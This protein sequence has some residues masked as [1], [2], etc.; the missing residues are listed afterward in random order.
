MGA[1]LKDGMVAETSGLPPSFFHDPLLGDIW[2]CILAVQDADGS[3]DLPR[4]ASELERY[5]LE[6]SL[7]IDASGLVDIVGDRARSSSEVHRCVGVVRQ[8]YGDRIMALELSERLRELKEGRHAE[9]LIAGHR[10]SLTKLEQAGGRPYRTAAQ[11]ISDELA[12]IRRERENPQLKISG[13]E[14]PWGLQTAVPG[15]VP[16]SKL[17]ILFGPTGTFK[18]TIINAL[19]RHWAEQDIGKIV[20]FGLEDPFIF[21]IQKLLSAL[22]GI[23]LARIIERDLTDAE[24]E[25]LE[26][27]G[28]AWT[29]NIVIIE[30]VTPTVEEMIRA[31]RAV[32]DV[33]GVVYDYAQMLDWGDDNERVALHKLSLEAHRAGKADN[34]AQILLSQLRE[35]KQE[36]A[37]DENKRP[38]YQW[39]FGGSSVYKV[40]KLC[41]G[42]YRPW[43]F[44][45]NG[46]KS[47]IDKEMYGQWYNELPKESKGPEW[48]SLVE[49]VLAKNQVGGTRRGQP[50]YVELDTGIVK[51]W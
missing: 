28:A 33:V 41:I 29:K 31:Y 42:L 21:E 13:L 23:P 49:L 40:S 6:E 10:S 19:I 14:I 26:R 30:E 8:A 39:M 2:D 5:D 24:M 18:S 44:F 17:S 16:R 35:D 45:P 1:A 22:A 11:G 34:T 51:E 12:A 7:A 37:D 46:P 48:E 20:K 27:L 38:K 15:G 36:A 47:A 9:E 32:P 50:V 4:V 3:V 25:R 43:S